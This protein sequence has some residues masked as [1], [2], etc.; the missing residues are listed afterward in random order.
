[1]CNAGSTT[2]E[3]TSAGNIPLWYACVDQHKSVVE[4]LLRCSYFKILTVSFISFRQPHDTHDLLDDE[5][6]V[7]HLMKLSK[8]CDEK[9]T[10]PL[11]CIF[12]G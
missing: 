10:I 7:Y 4:Y 11:N 3:K 12:P 8:V 5:K 6:F 9:S 2:T 1:M